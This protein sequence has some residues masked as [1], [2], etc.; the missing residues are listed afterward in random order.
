MSLIHPTLPMLVARVHEQEAGTRAGY[1]GSSGAYDPRDAPQAARATREAVRALCSFGLRLSSTHSFRAGTQHPKL[2]VRL[3]ACLPRA[4]G[5]FCLRY[6]HALVRLH[7]PD[8]HAV[9]GLEI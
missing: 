4:T 5:R 2:R 8:V 9:V 1:G 6:A 3:Y 7:A